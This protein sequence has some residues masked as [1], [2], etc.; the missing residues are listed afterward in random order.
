VDRSR[1]RR[2]LEQL[3]LQVP[4]RIAGVA[5]AQIQPPKGNRKGDR[6]YSSKKAG[7]EFVLVSE[8]VVGVGGVEPPSSSV[9]DPTSLCRPVRG[10]VRNGE[11]SMEG[12]R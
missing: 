9:S 6:R 8:D 5:A 12:R 11:G 3:A 7:T 1:V 10:T 2:R 4:D